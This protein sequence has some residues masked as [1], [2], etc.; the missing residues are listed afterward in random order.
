M[1]WKDK[2][3]ERKED[4]DEQVSTAASDHEHADGRN[5]KENE[6]QLWTEAALPV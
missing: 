1:G 5:Y 3:E 4:I 6:I 2:P